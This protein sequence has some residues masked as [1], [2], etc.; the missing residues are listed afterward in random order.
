MADSGCLGTNYTFTPIWNA[1]TSPS[2]AMTNYTWSPG[3]TVSPSTGTAFSLTTIPIPT[4]CATYTLT[5]VGIDTA[6]ADNAV[7]NPGFESDIAGWTSSYGVYTVTGSSVGLP[8]CHYALP[9]DA[10][11]YHPLASHLMPHS[12]SKFFMVNGCG[13]TD[14]ASAPTL[15]SQSLTLCCGTSY[16][17]S[18]WA[19][20]WSDYTYG[21]PRIVVFMNG[22]PVFSVN[23]T[24][25]TSLWKQ[26][27]FDYTTAACGSGSSNVTITFKTV[28]AYSDTMNNDF[29]L[30]DIAVQRICTTTNTLQLCPVNI[31]PIVGYNQICVGSATELFEVTTGGTWSSSSPG[32]ATVSTYT[33]VVTGI[34]PGTATITYTGSLGCYVIFPVTINPNPAPFS[35]SSPLCVGLTEP[36]TDADV[37]GTWSSSS[38]PTASVGTGSGIIYGNAPGAA[39]ISYTLSTGCYATEPLTVNTLPAIYGPSALCAGATITL[40]DDSTGGTWSS[41]DPSVSLS[42]ACV[43]TGVGAGPATITYSYGGC[44][45]YDL[46]SVNTMPEAISPSAIALCAGGNQMFTDPTPGGS[47][48]S[49]TPSVTTIT[50]AGLLNALAVGTDVVTYDLSGCYVTAAVTV[51][52][53]P[54]ITVSPAD[55][56]CAGSSLTLS[57]DLSGGSWSM[58]V[59]LGTLSASGSDEVFTAGAS[60]GVVNISYTIDAT[61]C[62]ATVAVTVDTIL[63]SGLITGSPDTICVGNTTVLTTGGTPGGIWT[64]GDVTIATVD[65]T[66]DASTALVTG[67]GGGTVVLTYTVADACGTWSSTFAVTVVAF[68]LS[69]PSCV[70]NY[71]VPGV[72][73]YTPLFSGSTVTASSTF[74]PGNYYLD[75]SITIAAGTSVTFNGCVVLMAAGVSI[76]V[77]SGAS[78]SVQ[79]CHLFCCY[80]DMWQGFVHSSSGA[81][82]PGASGQLEVTSNDSNTTLIEDALVAV[83]VPGAVSSAMYAAGSSGSISLLTLYVHG[84]T[85]NK[86]GIGIRVSGCF[87]NIPTV[88]PPESENPGY[89]FVVR[90]AVFTCR[91]FS[92]VPSWPYSWP[93]TEDGGA[94]PYALKNAISTD[95]YASPYN[96]DNY[97]MTSCNQAGTIPPQV[98]I[99]LENVGFT[100]ST[101]GTG[102][103]IFSDF[104][105]GGAN[106]SPLYD[107]N[108]F[109][110][111]NVGINSNNSNLI[112]RN[113]SFTHMLASLGTGWG[114]LAYR[115]GT[116]DDPNLKRRLDVYGNPES[117]YI[118]RFWDCSTC[119]YAADIYD[120]NINGAAMCSQH[121]YSNMSD[122]QG[123]YGIQLYPTFFYNNQVRNCNIAN[124]STGVYG[125]NQEPWISGATSQ[126][127]QTTISNNVFSSTYDGRMPPSTGHK[128]YM[129]QAVYWVNLEGSYTTSD[130]I[131]G[132]EENIDSNK[133]NGVFNGIAVYYNNIND[134]PQVTTSS[135]NNITLAYDVFTGMSGW[136]VGAI[137]AGIQYFQTI[138][139]Y[140][141]DNTITGPGYNTPGQLISRGY[142]LPGNNDEMVGIYMNAVQKQWTECNTISDINTGTM[143]DGINHTV[144]WIN[145]TMTRNFFGYV[146]GHRMGDGITSFGPAHAFNNVW[147]DYTWWSTTTGVYQTYVAGSAAASSAPMEVYSPSTTLNPSINNA[148]YISNRYLSGSSIFTSSDAGTNCVYPDQAT[149]G[150]DYRI[151]GHSVGMGDS[152]AVKYALSPNPNGGSFALTRPLPA[153]TAATVEIYN[154]IGQRV[155][156]SDVRFNAGRTEIGIPNP[157]PG[158][159]LLRLKDEDNGAFQ[160][161]FEIRP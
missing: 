55:S 18:F 149:V 15:L 129:Y 131:G 90:N 77:E 9:G 130:F 134:A 32:V 107:Q 105:V 67:V 83:D 59:A 92:T 20:N 136:S 28:D 80:P 53:T 12:G 7:T 74:G 70:C 93:A 61:G 76:T 58:D 52:P 16:R 45:V 35:V 159:Y 4:V 141:A 79:G 161:K 150:P 82:G 48:S 155:F 56:V 85:F 10:H 2:Y 157:T 49:G 117:K 154:A 135:F 95:V 64:S 151:G 120:V 121:A 11:D 38:P 127:G 110:N 140:I 146:L 147:D 119:I 139:G 5:T 31:E 73:P 29:G 138:N 102:Y 39:T 46:I 51:N 71:L 65:A 47:W 101:L 37:G 36:V 160:M 26:Y 81:G 142:G 148:D 42:G 44:T 104:V 153:N 63:N 78:A 57:D 128:D 14:L 43:V 126:I 145:N 1:G 17:V 132:S 156:L 6:A 115:D 99:D 13:T 84:A 94:T 122:P 62:T 19:A 60:A 96:L 75:H 113:S 97:A 111:M 54:S 152:T 133:M 34:T 124:I 100:N 103:E 86:N 106:P 143:F 41:S 158:V 144:Y 27:S 116:A 23:L 87:D 109:D 21:T 88:T 30:D 114:I 22:D 69:A 33:G 72:A 24:T 66:G 112:V 50:A 3:S 25:D 91:D 125:M 68:P 123:N 8:S 118:D 137:Q 98:G 89:P 108:L 40:A